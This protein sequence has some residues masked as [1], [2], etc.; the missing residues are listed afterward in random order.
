MFI[1]NNPNDTLHGAGFTLRTSDASADS[2]F[3]VRRQNGKCLLLAGSSFTAIPTE[4]RL[5]Y[6]GAFGSETVASGYAHKITD[7]TV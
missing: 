1:E 7:T 6:S 3:A 4:L 2:I 5:G